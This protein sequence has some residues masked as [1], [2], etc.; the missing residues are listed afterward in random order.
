MYDPQKFKLWRDV[1]DGRLSPARTLDAIRSFGARFVLVSHRDT[2]MPFLQ[3]IAE[4]PGVG[5]GYTDDHRT[6]LTVPTRR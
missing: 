2:W 5:I 1:S 4:A 3:K 6:V